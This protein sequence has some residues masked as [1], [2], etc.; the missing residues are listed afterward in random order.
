[1]LFLAP[2]F[3]FCFGIVPFSFSFRC[4]HRSAH[5]YF[6]R[7]TTRIRRFVTCFSRLG[8][9]VLLRS[10]SITSGLH[11]GAAAL[12]IGRCLASLRLGVG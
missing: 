4:E 6:T 5:N 8:R 12:G 2:L 10:D 3:V 9:C 11:L 1:M 7:R